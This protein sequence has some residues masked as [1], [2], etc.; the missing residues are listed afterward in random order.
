MG[1]GRILVGC[2]GSETTL[3]HVAGRVGAEAFAYASDYPHE[4]D[5]PAAI[6]EIEEVAGRND[7]SGADKAKILGGN[8]HAFF[9]I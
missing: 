4:V 5:L 9:A 3:A 1:G 6:H 8:A 2:E 7:L